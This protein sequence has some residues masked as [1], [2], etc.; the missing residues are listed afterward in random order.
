MATVPNHNQQ[1]G[2]FG[3]NLAAQYLEKRG[4]QIVARNWRHK[5]WELDLICTRDRM[6]HIIEVKT[7]NSTRYGH[8]EESI[9]KE[10]FQIMKNGAEVFME[11]HPGYKYLQFDVV[12]ILLQPPMPPEIILFEDI[13]Y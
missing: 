2:S 7:R 3:E 12:A 8:P 11:L 13:Y 10:K 9:K 1:T 6:L 4:Y 5:H